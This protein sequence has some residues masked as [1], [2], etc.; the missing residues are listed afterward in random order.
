MLHIRPEDIVIS[1]HAADTS[2]RNRLFGTVT[3]IT[4]L[5]PTVRLR[6]SAEK[7]IV[8]I[9]TRR[10]FFEMQL[11]IGSEVYAFFKVTSVEVL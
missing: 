2:A 5:G 11:N 1:K 8:A 3:E 10:S 9:I 6:V 4:D 7:P